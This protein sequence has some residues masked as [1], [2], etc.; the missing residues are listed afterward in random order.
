MLGTTRISLIGTSHFGHFGSLMRSPRSRCANTHQTSPR[1]MAAKVIPTRPCNLGVLLNTTSPGQSHRG[2]GA[3]LLTADRLPWR[4][5][6][7]T[8]LVY[9]PLGDTS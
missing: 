4:V 8:R 2:A 9:V 1:W 3:S 7:L 6:L 5:D